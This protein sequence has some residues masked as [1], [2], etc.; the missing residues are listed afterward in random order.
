MTERRAEPP[1][2]PVIDSLYAAT[3]VGR[4]ERFRPLFLWI[5][6]LLF[7]ALG[8]GVGWVAHILTDNSRLDRMEAKIN[9]IDTNVST[10]VAKLNKDLL[11]DSSEKPGRVTKLERD[12]RIVWREITRA[13]VLAVATET[14]RTRQGKRNAAL[15]LLE[16]YDHLLKDKST[17]GDPITAYTEALDKVAIR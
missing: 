12:Q 14:E 11:D 1:P 4:S 6:G 10:L 8:S 5:G 9:T 16:S 13:R 7:T 17:K 15:N 2:A 3:I